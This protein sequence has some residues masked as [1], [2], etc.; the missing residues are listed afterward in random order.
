[1]PDWS[2]ICERLDAAG[3][4]VAAAAPRPVSGGDIS[5]AWR[6]GTDAG[7][8][9]LKT[10]PASSL[11]MFT[12]EAEGLRELAAAAAV[13][14]PAVIAAGEAGDTAFLAL[15]WLVF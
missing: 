13:K 2:A 8:L 14:V 15:E 3:V 9:F 11:D 1:M 5:A 12:A 7:D 4:G 6:L 10:G